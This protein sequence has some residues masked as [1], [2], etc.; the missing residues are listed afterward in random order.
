MRPRTEMMLLF[1]TLMAVN[2]ERVKMFYIKLKRCPKAGHEVESDFKDKTGEFKG[3]PHTPQAALGHAP[4]PRDEASLSPLWIRAG[5]GRPGLGPPRCSPSQV[6]SCLPPTLTPDSG[7]PSGGPHETPKPH[8]RARRQ[9][10]RRSARQVL[11]ASPW[12]G[13]LPNP[14]S[15]AT[16]AS[17][18]VIPGC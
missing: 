3:T 8:K 14:R 2:S 13:R 1:R 15:W 16:L 11:S 18:L 9:R 7:E 12:G 5:R 6:P 17:R 10:V 4:D